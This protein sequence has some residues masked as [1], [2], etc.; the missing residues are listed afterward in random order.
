MSWLDFLIQ[1]LTFR[2][3]SKP[4]NRCFVEKFRSFMGD[5]LIEAASWSVPSLPIDFNSSQDQIKLGG[6][7]SSCNSK[8]GLL[9]LP[10]PLLECQY[11]HYLTTDWPNLLYLSQGKVED[12]IPYDPRSKIHP[13]VSNSKVGCQPRHVN[14]TAGVLSYWEACRGGWAG[15][16][17]SALA[18]GSLILF[19]FAYFSIILSRTVL[20]FSKF[21]R[22]FKTY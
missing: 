1:L 15:I 4:S 17:S 16:C 21:Y 11:L 18:T 2:S 8:W 19:L 3:G 10:L 13:L 22:I 20:N 6:R 7:K 5:G 14:T 12:S 9:K